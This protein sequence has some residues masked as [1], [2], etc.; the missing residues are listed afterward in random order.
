MSVRYAAV[1]VD[2][3]VETQ[4]FTLNWLCDSGLQAIRLGDCDV[5][6]AGGS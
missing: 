6:V 5:A 3:P 1:N 2:L 4:A